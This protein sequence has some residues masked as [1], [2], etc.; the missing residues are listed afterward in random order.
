MMVKEFQEVGTQNKI[1]NKLWKIIL[2]E[3][4]ELIK[5]KKINLQ[6]HVKAI[7]IC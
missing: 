7:A 3:S 1:M 5:Q 2:T 4:L 6:E